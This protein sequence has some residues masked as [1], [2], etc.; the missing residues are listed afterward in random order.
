MDKISAITVSLWLLYAAFLARVV[1]Q[2]LV[3]LGLAPWLPPF[4]QWQSGIV[5]YE[6][7]LALQLMVL[8]TFGK[9]AMDITANSGYFSATRPRLAAI[10]KGV[11]LLYGAVVIGRFVIFHALLPAHA[12]LAPIIPTI[13]HVDLAAFILIASISMRGESQAPAS[14]SQR[15]RIRLR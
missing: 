12:N 10:L 8:I 1:G 13:L 2:I 14:A 11:S 6:V 15:Q 4:E 7:L 9:V 3:A 5:S